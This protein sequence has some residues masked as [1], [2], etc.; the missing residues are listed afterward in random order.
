MSPRSLSLV[1]TWERSVQDSGLSSSVKHVALNLAT[2][3]SRSG[4]SAFPGL[5]RQALDCSLG[6][7]TVIKALR[8]LLEEGWLVRTVAGGGR[9]RRAEY[10]ARLPETVGSDDRFH[11]GRDPSE[12]GSAT[13]TAPLAAAGGRGRQASPA[14]SETVGSDDRFRVGNGRSGMGKGSISPAETVDLSGVNGRPAGT[15]GTR[16]SHEVEAAAA[17]AAAGLA[18]AF[19]GAAA[20][21]LEEELRTLKAGSRLRELA[22][23][24][25]ERALAWVQ[26]AK[27]EA[28]HPAGFVRAGLESGEW[29]SDRQGGDAFRTEA[30][31]RRWIEEVGWRLDP[32][33]A[34]L[35][36]EER[37]SKLLIGEAELAELRDHLQAVRDRNV[38]DPPAELRGVA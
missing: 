18:D 10:E 21:A 2:Y 33:H 29:P 38:G 31:T 36:L 1:K 3:M 6:K 4:T 27:L 20:A 25:P 32:E 26:V 7:D 37:C 14:S 16:T 22:H 11:D 35:I 13:L 28:Q 5:R 17:T 30:S 8:V 19:G 15:E 9:G 24:D 23:T 12:E 34:E